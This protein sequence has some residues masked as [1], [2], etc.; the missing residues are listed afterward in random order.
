MSLVGTTQ[1]WNDGKSVLQLKLDRSR[2]WP[3]LLAFLCLRLMAFAPCM[4]PQTKSKPVKRAAVQFTWATKTLKQLSLQEKIGQL[5]MPAFRGT[6]LNSQSAEFKEIERQ[7]R[8]NHVG[9]FILFAGDVYE[10][11]ILIDKMQS[12]S[13]LPLLIAS[14]FERGANFRIRNTVSFPWNMAIGATGS[15]HWAEVQGR[16]TAQEARA[17]GVDW[18]FA[19]V[20]DVNN[21]PYNPVINIRSFGEDAE[22]VA[23][24]GGAFVRG[25]Q[26]AGVLA[27]GKHFP[28][29]GDT[30]VDSHLELPLVPADRQR[31]E[32]ME[33]V[34]FKKAIDNGVWAI[35]TAHLAVPTLESDPDIPATLSSK[36]LHGALQQEL[37]FSNLVVT[38]SLKM[39]GLTNGFWIGD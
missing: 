6:Y 34:P 12:L 26:Q 20:L 27:T 7:I 29:H 4:L 19:P 2:K 9:G 36:V 35:M 30:G 8:K 13:K 5:I 25:A 28:G 14:D 32:R 17:M 1:W 31:L 24:L 21:N 10:S 15:E 18:I 22:L 37:G 23:R 16:I 3:F 33:F 39:A 11:A 38:D